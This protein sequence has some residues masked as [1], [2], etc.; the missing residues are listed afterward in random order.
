M[1]ISLRL[2]SPYTSLMEQPITEVFD[3]ANDL[4]TLARS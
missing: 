4:K 1:Q 2:H 3:L